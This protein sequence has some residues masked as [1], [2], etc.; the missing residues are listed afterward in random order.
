MYLT[1]NYGKTFAAI[2]GT[3]TN[4]NA[5]YVSA[6]SGTGQYMVCGSSN[7]GQQALFLSTNYG[8]TWTAV[9]SANVPTNIAPVTIGISRMANI[10]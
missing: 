6:V 3:L 9:S 1:T 5:W 2:G 8:V 4:G 7:V 10:C